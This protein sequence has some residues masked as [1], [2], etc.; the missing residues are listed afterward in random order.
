MEITIVLNE[1]QLKALRTLDLID[2]VQEIAN[3]AVAT[4]IRG[5]YKYHAMKAKEQTAKSYD[6]A[7]RSGAK[8][9]ADKGAF[10]SHYMK[11]IED[12]LREL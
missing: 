5:K 3:N 6:W 2:S 1:N 10:V 11:E 4:A 12:T 7:V 8:F 9:D